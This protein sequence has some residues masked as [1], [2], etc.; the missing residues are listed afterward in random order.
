MKYNVKFFYIVIV[1]FFASS[2]ILTGCMFAIAADNGKMKTYDLMGDI[3]V[4]GDAPLSQDSLQEKYEAMYDISKDGKSITVISKEYLDNYWGSNYEKGIIHSLK[5]EEVYYI[6]QD[7]IRIY[8]MYENVILLGFPHFEDQA[9]VTCKVPFAENS[10]KC[11]L[12]IYTIIMYRLTA[13]SSSEAFFTGAE[14]ICSVGGDPAMY[15]GLFP[16]S[17]FYIPDY[18]ADTDRDY[19]LSVMGGSMDHMDSDRFSDLFVVSAWGDPVIEF[20]SKTNGSTTKVF[21][22][23]DMI[24]PN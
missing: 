23:N 8:S 5:P 11:I 12:D 6:I 16:E 20:F 13:L 7:S 10:D 1:L 22:T 15:N 18:S 3:I 21:P 24:N 2:I 17:V 14:A 4:E 19:I 9:I